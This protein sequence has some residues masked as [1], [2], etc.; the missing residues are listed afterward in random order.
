MIM[1]TYWAVPILKPRLHTEQLTLGVLRMQQKKCANHSDTSSN[2]YIESTRDQAADAT[3]PTVC[4]FGGVLAAYT[5]DG[6]DCTADAPP[7]L[8]ACIYSRLACAS[9]HACASRAHSSANADGGIYHLAKP[10]QRERK[11][12][13]GK[14][15][16][17]VKRGSFSV[18]LTV[19]GDSRW[20]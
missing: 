1:C 4:A 10:M 9:G 2:I 11:R 12:Y 16:D 8:V 20:L 3:R 14:S 19:N 13:R 7:E 18:G 17:M 15:I 6:C 5:F